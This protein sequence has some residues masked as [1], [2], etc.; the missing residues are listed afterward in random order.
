MKHDR[1]D[2]CST[3]RSCKP[4]QLWVA[5]AVVVLVAVGSPTA[6]QDLQ[7]VQPDC[8]VTVVTEADPLVPGG[9]R[10]TQV[11]RHSTFACAFNLQ[12]VVA[13]TGIAV[14]V[15]VLSRAACRTECS[16]P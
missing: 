11:T 7:P 3:R 1:H 4:I 2:A 9:R 15:S 8:N 12:A 6:A 14:V 5:V 16:I 10:L 13:A